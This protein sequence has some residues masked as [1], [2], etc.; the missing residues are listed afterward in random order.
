MSWSGRKSSKFEILILN[1]NTK[2]K[3]YGKQQIFGDRYE[4][5]RKVR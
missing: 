2:E 1:K 3:K 4:G 5:G